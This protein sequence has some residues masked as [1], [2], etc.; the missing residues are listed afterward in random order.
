MG[1]AG[2]ACIPWA[3]ASTHRRH[4]TKGSCDALL[5]SFLF[6]LWEREPPWCTWHSW[7]APRPQPQPEQMGFGG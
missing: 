6:Y 5:E 1:V 7:L 2:A 4:L 3:L